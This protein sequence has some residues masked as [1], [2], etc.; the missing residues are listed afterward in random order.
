MAVVSTLVACNAGSLVNCY[1]AGNV[2]TEEHSVYAG[3]V[4]GWVTG[5]GQAR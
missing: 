2:E 4:S 1:A 3:M 5:I